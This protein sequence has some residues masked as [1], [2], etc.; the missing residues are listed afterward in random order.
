MIIFITASLTVLKVAVCGHYI[1]RLKG[2]GRGGYRHPRVNITSVKQPSALFS[3]HFSGRQLDPTSTDFLQSGMNACVEFI[4]YVCVSDL[5][6]KNILV[7][8]VIEN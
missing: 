5:F 6:L 7:L 8:F 3:T 4:H 2:W 1:S